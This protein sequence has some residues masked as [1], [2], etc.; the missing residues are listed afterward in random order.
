MECKEAK[1]RKRSSGSGGWPKYC[2]G[3]LSSVIRRL[4]ARHPVAPG[5]LLNDVSLFPAAGEGRVREGIM[6]RRQGID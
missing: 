6:G 4:F 3:Q 1:G 5:L 2:E